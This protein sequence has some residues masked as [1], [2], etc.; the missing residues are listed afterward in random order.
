MIISNLLETDITVDSVTLSSDTEK[1][2][3]LS[4][5]ILPKDARIEG[6]DIEE[7]V[8]LG[9]R[10]GGKARILK[11]KFANLSCR[12]NAFRFS[13]NLNSPTVYNSFGRVYI[14]KDMSYLR[15]KEEKRLRD[16]YHS[17]KNDYP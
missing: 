16:E 6:S 4:N 1:V 11:M 8:W 13:R 10:G 9:N 17:L 7:I 3:A 14:N 12:N 5:A 2:V 15:R